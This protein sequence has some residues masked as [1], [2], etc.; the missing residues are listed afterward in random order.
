[1]VDRYQQLADPNALAD[2]GRLRSRLSSGA[3]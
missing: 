3:L 2:T 1:M